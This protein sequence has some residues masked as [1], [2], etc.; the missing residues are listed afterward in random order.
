MEK[1]NREIEK[2]HNI[3]LIF[4]IRCKFQFLNIF[5][6]LQLKQRNM[7]SVVKIECSQ[8]RGWII[9]ISTSVQVGE[10][11]KSSHLQFL[12]E[13][14]RDESIEEERG[15]IVK[16]EFGM[17]GDRLVCSIV[18]WP[19]NRARRTRGRWGNRARDERKSAG[20]VATDSVPDS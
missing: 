20:K 17:A 5:Y 6:Y 2:D 1:Y 14:R 12:G 15:L 19:G 7:R 8:F 16:G 10:I 11:I 9:F 13:R 4:N 18:V 3:R